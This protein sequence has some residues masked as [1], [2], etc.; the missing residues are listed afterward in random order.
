MCLI[1]PV[2]GWCLIILYY[3]GIG[4]YLSPL[5]GHHLLPLL[6]TMGTSIACGGNKLNGRATKISPNLFAAF[7]SPCCRPLIDMNVN[8]SECLFDFAVFLYPL[9]LASYLTTHV[10]RLTRLLVLRGIRV[11]SDECEDEDDL[12]CLT[13]IPSEGDN[14]IQ[15]RCAPQSVSVC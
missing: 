1:L 3:K 7:A 12:H 9:L 14:P 11:K 8:I 6:L 2:L 13:H 4:A 15:D 10:K 5:P